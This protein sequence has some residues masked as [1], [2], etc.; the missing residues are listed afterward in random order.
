MVERCTDVAAR[1]LYGEALTI[2]A[3][4]CQV[5]IFVALL[6]TGLQF[7]FEVLTNSLHSV[8]AWG[9]VDILQ[10]FLR[11]DT[12]KVL[13]IEQFS[14]GLSHAA[15]K[16]NHQV[17]AYWLVEH[18]EHTNLDVDPATVI[19]V[20]AYGFMKILPP[21]VEH[22][23][24][25]ESTENT[26]TQ[27]LRVAS[28]NGHPEVVEYLIGMVTDINAV[29]REV[30]CS[31]G[32][33]G[34]FDYNLYYHVDGSTRNLSA[35]Q[36]ALIGFQRF[37]P[38]GS[39]T[40]ADGSSQE[41]VIEILLGRGADPNK[42]DEDGKHPL[43]TAAEYCTIKVVQTLISSGANAEAATKEHG[44]ALQT[45]ACREMDGLPIILTLLKA[46]GSASSLGLG[47]AAA[48]D[49][50]LSFFDGR[51]I[52]S[53][54]IADVLG[55]GP[56]AV[57]KNLL[58]NLPEERAD[59]PRY[60]LLA[61]MACVAGDL[62]CIE[63]LLQRGMDV[64]ILGDYYGTALQA[65]S[66]VGNIRI[67]DCLMKSGADI[68]ILQGVYGTALRAA[69]IGG[70]EDLIHKL[71]THGA[72]VNLHYIDVIYPDNGESIL[73]LAIGSKNNEIFK[74]LLG[75][76]ADLNTEMNGQQHILIVA[77]EH[78]DINL[79]ELLLASGVDVNV[80]GTESRYY[81]YK[82]YGY[83]TPLIAACAKGHVSVVRLL[84]DHGADIETTYNS[85]V[86]P[87]IAAIRGNNSLI[88]Q[89][90][91][92]AGADVNHAADVTPLSEAA[93]N[94]DLEVIEDL[95]SAGAIFSDSSTKKNALA[96]A[97][98]SQRYMVA[99]LLLANLSCTQYEARIF[100]E[101]LSEAISCGDSKIVELLVEHGASP[102]FEMLR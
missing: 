94:C 54:S 89:V 90:L 82:E 91:L 45:A 29:V 69:V 81:A 17:V 66:R 52:K 25:K 67:V 11:Q 100:D 96:R 20:S 32:D 50:A 68:N 48:L 78:G 36:A 9:S 35:L 84:L 60:C 8:C 95:L 97:C 93:V 24:P 49:K 76:G 14:S 88:L 53:N 61:Q 102:S 98:G 99:E 28:S 40:K 13:G 10:K 57:V 62:E 33:T 44:T 85:S 80:L 18:P 27:C 30:R 1:H 34:L 58:A 37:K 59:D 83:V 51:F 42:A 71:I 15:R 70:H 79:V 6:E 86:T 22:I 75:A 92:D 2:A 26:L 73:H 46:S 47:T 55:T 7:D 21:L 23:R 3:A 63:L 4:N 12:K 101:A 38:Y 87:L 56:G 43:N 65:A 74:A 5:D 77:C 16:D 31:N 64:N 39:L 72:D 41:R 19:D